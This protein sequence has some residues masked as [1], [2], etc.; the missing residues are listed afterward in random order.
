MNIYKLEY[1][2]DIEIYIY[3]YDPLKLKKI[4]SST[5]LYTI[6]NIEFTDFCKVQT[7]EGVYDSGNL[8]DKY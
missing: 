3:I 2:K 1:F 7:L 5:K 4:N 6:T 8:L